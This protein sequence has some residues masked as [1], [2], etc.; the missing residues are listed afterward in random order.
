MLAM[1]SINQSGKFSP[2]A[3]E[4]EL[5]CPPLTAQKRNQLIPFLLL[6]SGLNTDLCNS[7]FMLRKPA[8]DVQ[9]AL[10]IDYF[11]QRFIKG[12]DS[13]GI[14]ANIAKSNP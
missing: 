10:A 3:P 8:G 13:L 11:F 12:I 4:A 5:I 14:R 7:L 6:T 1:S 9:L 2:G